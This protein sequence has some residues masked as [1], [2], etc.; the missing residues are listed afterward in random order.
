M[1][2]QYFYDPRPFY[3]INGH[4]GLLPLDEVFHGRY[5]PVPY[6]LDQRM[7][8]LSFEDS[9]YPSQKQMMTAP[10]RP[11]MQQYIHREDNLMAYKRPEVRDDIYTDMYK[12]PQQMMRPEVQD[13]IY[14]DMYRR[15]QQ[16]H[17]VPSGYRVYPE[18][19][20]LRGQSQDDM[21]LHFR[22]PMS[23]K[24]Q[25]QFTGRGLESQGMM[26]RNGPVQSRQSEAS[27]GPMP[28]RDNGSDQYRHSEMTM[29]S[30]MNKGQNNGGEQ[31]L[32][33]QMEMPMNNRP[34]NG[35]N[36]HSNKLMNMSSNQG[37]NDHKSW[38]NG[39]EN[40]SRKSQGQGGQSVHSNGNQ[41]NL[42]QRGFSQHDQSA[43]DDDDDDEYE[44]GSTGRKT[45]FNNGDSFQHKGEMQQH[46]SNKNVGNQSYS[47]P[48]TLSKPKSCRQ[49]QCDTQQV[50]DH[51]LSGQKQSKTSHKSHQDGWD[52]SSDDDESYKYTKKASKGQ[53]NQGTT[54]FQHSGHG[55]GHGNKEQF[56]LQNHG[57]QAKQSYSTNQSK[58]VELK[59][60]I[61]CDNCERKLRN[62]FEYMD[63]VENVLCDQWSRKV[64]V[65]GNVTADSVLKKVRR[66]KKASELWQQPKQLQ[67][68]IRAY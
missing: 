63:G 41:G 29:T 58:C 64:I 42:K 27:M 55:N 66:V 33:R 1:A 43:N 5:E 17:A 15:P 16:L 59:V 8:S 49:G 45:G 22:T 7:T 9:Y 31:V 50:H 47:S 61:C 26:V 19:K 54:N 48:Q 65:Y 52:S 6:W 3:G 2:G 35:N 34:N 37:G 51:N 10:L 30:Q 53:H 24:S 44:M 39:D 67:H 56:S 4:S 13:D 28:S 36:N 25:N 38:N 62:A 23:G 40:S 14:M 60:P 46:S 32:T 11:E 68:Q 21:W 57:Q 12:R 20:F 18:M